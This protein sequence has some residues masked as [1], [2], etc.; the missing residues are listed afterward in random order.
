MFFSIFPKLFVPLYRVITVLWCRRC[1]VHFIHEDTRPPALQW[2]GQHSSLRPSLPTL[3]SRVSTHSP[4]LPR[5]FDDC[6]SCMQPLDVLPSQP[7]TNSWGV[8]PETGNKCSSE[9]SVTRLQQHQSSCKRLNEWPPVPPHEVRDW[10]NTW[11]RPGSANH[12]S[13]CPDLEID[14]YTSN[15]QLPWGHLPPRAQSEIMPREQEGSELSA[16][17][18]CIF[19]NP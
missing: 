4:L 8:C 11:S 18:T 5:A 16:S 12:S 17:F 15:G 9:L 14:T 3:T 1:C 19:G 2:R 6:G 7:G 10:V 13:D